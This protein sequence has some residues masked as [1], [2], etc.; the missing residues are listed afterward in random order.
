MYVKIVVSAIKTAR[1]AGGSRRRKSTRQDLD[2][3]HCHL[4]DLS[5]VDES[6]SRSKLQQ[7]EKRLVDFGGSQFADGFGVSD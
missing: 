4:E 5:P 3:K 1:S 2:A 7:S 6:F